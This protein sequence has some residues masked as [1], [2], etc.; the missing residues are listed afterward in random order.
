MELKVVLVATVMTTIMVTESEMAEAV[1]F[2]FSDL[3]V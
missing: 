2:C 3:W 1:F